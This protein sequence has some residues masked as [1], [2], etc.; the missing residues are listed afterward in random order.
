MGL[1]SYLRDHGLIENMRWHDDTEMTPVAID[2]WNILYMLLKR[3]C[4]SN[5]ISTEEKNFE[6]LIALFNTLLKKQ[7]VPIFV[8]DGM[9]NASHM[10][11]GAKAIGARRCV[12]KNNESTNPKPLYK[13]CRKFIEAAG[14]PIVCIKG[15]EADEACANLFHTRTVNFVIS[16]DSDLL[17]MGCDIILDVIPMFPP[18]VHFH[19]LLHHLNMNAELFLKWFVKC[20]TDL[21]G[22]E[23]AIAF[24]EALM[25]LKAI[26]S[27][28]KT[29]S[30]KRCETQFVTQVKRLIKPCHINDKLTLLKRVPIKLGCMPNVSYLQELFT[31]YKS[32]SFVKW[33]KRF[34]CKFIQAQQLF[35]ELYQ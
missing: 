12:K 23:G 20:H 25:R 30:S 28:S 27:N 8:F 16:A 33:K 35:P 11:Q 15:L 1:L 6:C 19:N 18:C 10:G 13:F 29:L 31:K 26:R 34:I 4:G 3:S 2:T 24:S 21:H 22:K 17:L 5:P 9:F 7:F 14:F 32:V